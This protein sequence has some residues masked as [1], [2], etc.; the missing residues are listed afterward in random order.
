MKLIYCT[1]CQDVVSIR[2][3]KV[4]SCSCGKS[5][6][7]YSDV[8][9]AWFSGPAI[10]LGFANRSFIRAVAAQPKHA[11]GMDFVAFVIEKDCAT[12]KKVE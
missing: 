9:N 7:Q 12:V 6:G 11:P 8:L 4:V 10:P 1:V 2:P 5:K 3:D